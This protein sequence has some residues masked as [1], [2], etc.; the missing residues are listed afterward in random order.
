MAWPYHTKK[1]HIE[2]SCLLEYYALSLGKYFPTF[3]I[4]VLPSFAKWFGQRNTVLHYRRLY[5]LLVPLWEWCSSL[6]KSPP[7]TSVASF[8]LGTNVFLGHAVAQLVEALRYKSQGRG[9]EY[10]RCPSDRTLALGS[11][12]PLTEMSI[13]NIS[14]AYR[15][16]VR[17]TDK[18]TTFMCRLS[19]NLGASTSWNPQ[20]L[21]PNYT[22]LH[23][24]TP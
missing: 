18:L 20:G 3:R 7:H 24:K 12:K 10:Q 5:T 14:W 6:Y 13:R 15:P 16:P 22:A 23:P 1:T 21:S 11:T 4:M 8:F 9:F 19:W 17:R 2:T